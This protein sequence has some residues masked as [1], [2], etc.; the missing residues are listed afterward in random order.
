MPR[1]VQIETWF[2]GIIHCTL[3]YGLNMLSNIVIQ[4]ESFKR[5][6]NLP[7]WRT[8]LNNVFF[9]IAISLLRAPPPPPDH[10]GSYLKKNT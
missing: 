9:T 2:S 7:F 6:T 5:Q 1:L 10:S 8:S 3:K 4:M